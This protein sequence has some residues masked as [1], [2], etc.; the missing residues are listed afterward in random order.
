MRNAIEMIGS[1]FGSLTVVGRHGSDRHGQAL[2][3]CLCSCGNKT[4]VLGGHLRSGTTKTCGIGVCSSSYKHGHHSHPLYATWAGMKSRVFNENCKEY[5][6]Y[7]GRGIKICDRWLV[8]DNFIE[9]MYPSYIEGLS[10]DRIHVNGNYCKENCRWETE[11]TQQHVKRKKKGCSSQYIG[12]HFD[13]AAGK[14][15]ANI[16]HLHERHQ[17][18]CFTNELEAATAYD[19]LSEELYGDRPNS[20]N[21]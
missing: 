15:R 5:K 11:S 1:T 17:L 19:N 12:V 10:L 6:N 3:E 13:K 20:T 9:D 2:W 21:K 7:G 16:T 8:L 18:G 14:F 4:V